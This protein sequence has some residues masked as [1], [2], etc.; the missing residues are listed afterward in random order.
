MSGADCGVPNNREP[1]SEQKLRTARWPLP[2]GTRDCFTGPECVKD[3]FGTPRMGTPPLP[4]ARWQ[5]RQWQ[6]TENKAGPD[7][8]YCTEPQRQW[9]VNIDASAVA[10]RV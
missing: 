10:E 8:R 3:D 2:P 1:H 9:P 4:D 7:D 5:S 6:T